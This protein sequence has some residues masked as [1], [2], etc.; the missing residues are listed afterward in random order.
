MRLE[1]TFYT[2]EELTCDAHTAQ[3]RLSMAAEHP[4]YAGH[5]PAQAVVPGVCTLTIIR[6]V[7][8][9]IEGAE[10]AFDRIKECKFVSALLPREG[11]KLTLDF[12]WGEDQSLQCTVADEQKCVLKLKASWRKR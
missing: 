8:A 3:C 6:E 4:I 12:V 7:L 1:G 11:L 2:I 9:K 10:V 5:F